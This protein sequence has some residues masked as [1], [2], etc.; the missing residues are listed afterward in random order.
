MSDLNAKLIEQGCNVYLVGG[1]VRD[2][3]LDKPVKDRDFV[4]TGATP[5][6]MLQLGFSQVGANFP[7]FLHP[8][9]NEEYALARTEKKVGAGYLGF[10]ANFEPTTTIEDDLFRRDLTMNA[11]AINLQTN[12]VIDPFDG[13]SDIRR[14]ILHHVSDH[15]AEDPLRV[16]RVARFAARYDFDVEPSTRELMKRLVD[17]G[18]LN[19][20]SKDRVW[21][22]FERGLLEAKPWRFFQELQDC[23]ALQTLGPWSA[24]G[25]KQI[26]HLTRITAKTDDLAARFL[27][28]AV[29]FTTKDY[30][31]W[32]VPANL[33]ARNNV[34]QAVGQDLKRFEQLNEEQQLRVLAMCRAREEDALLELMKLVAREPDA[35]FNMLDLAVLELRRLDLETIVASGKTGPEKKRLVLAAFRSALMNARRKFTCSLD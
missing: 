2:L 26:R 15:F 9:T 28:V 31:D 11:I 34:W 7:V 29:G 25:Q 10:E 22:E 30:A 33:S 23:G 16:L 24:V 18:E 19:H 6:L 3:T 1:A 12:E 32:R 20:L 8:E 21:K 13:L 14:G 4:V 27:T 5:E 17:A 35:T